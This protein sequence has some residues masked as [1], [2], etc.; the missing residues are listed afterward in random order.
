MV[1]GMNIL[2]ERMNLCIE[3][4][5]IMV[6]GNGFIVDGNEFMVE[7]TNI[8]V[9]EIEYEVDGTRCRL[10]KTNPGM[11]GIEFFASRGRDYS[12]CGQLSYFEAPA[13]VSGAFATVLLA[14]SVLEVE[15]PCTSFL[16]LLKV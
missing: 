2:V 10:E 7:G 8:M 12:A 4:M 3:V 16:R 14:A 15:E 11:L 13:C 9:E 5:N 1:D 6:D